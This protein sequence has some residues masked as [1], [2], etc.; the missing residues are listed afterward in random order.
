MA[1]PKD[2]KIEQC[3]RKIVPEAK[4]KDDTEFTVKQARLRAEAELKLEEGFLKTDPEWNERSKAIIEAAFQDDEEKEQAVRSPAQPKQPTPSRKAPEPL[5]QTTPIRKAPATPKPTSKPAD[6]QPKPQQSS[7]K[8]SPVGSQPTVSKKKAPEA[9]SK[10]VESQAEDATGSESSEED[11]S[12]EGDDEESEQRDKDKDHTQPALKKPEGTSPK[13]NGVKRKAGEES[14]SGESSGSEESEDEDESKEGLDEPEPKKAKMNSTDSSDQSSEDASEDAAEDGS[15]DE[16]AKS[17]PK[18]AEQPVQPVIAAIP[19]KTFRPPEGY[20]ALSPE[21]LTHDTAFSHAMLDG[22]QIW[23]ITAPS[24]VPL[25]SITEVALDAVQ[26]SQTVL[27]HKGVD[28]ALNEDRSKGKDAA[29]VLVPTRDGYEQA[30]QKVSRVLQLQQKITLPNLSM[31]QANPLTGSKAAGDIAEAAV[32]RLRPQPKGLRMRY[33]PP[34][35][36]AGKPGRIGSGSESTDEDENPAPG[37]AF[38]F[39]RALGA[40][41]TSTQQNGDVEM[42]DESVDAQK[43]TKKPKK[44]RKDKHGSED[45]APKVNGVSNSKSTPQAAT[46]QQ[47]QTYSDDTSTVRPATKK[48]AETPVATLRNGTAP[49]VLSKEDKAKRKEA[50]KLAETPASSLPNGTAPEVISKEDKAKRKEAKRLKKEA[51]RRKDAGSVDV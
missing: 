38:Q 44:K 5:K 7:K 22:K 16:N 6:S 2:S 50:K 40:H 49:V 41:G 11:G 32:T 3:L 14:S 43:S 23:H 30:Q 8:D 19:A 35:F 27:T 13:V 26:S 45:P 36:G 29:T 31:R 24:N 20:T 4:A 33:R 15:G 37:P 17:T 12:G 10:L 42:A 48:V 47:Q 21:Q 46:K 28:Y 18:P 9:P 51:E 34:G 1:R 39:P 25:S